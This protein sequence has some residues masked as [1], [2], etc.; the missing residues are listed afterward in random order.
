MA[1]KSAIAT[2]V[3]RI[4]TLALIAASIALLATNKFTVDG[5]KTTFKDVQAYKYVISA[6]LLG[7]L[8]TL[9]QIPFAIYHVAT[10]KRVIRNE[11][12][13]EFDFYADQIV[14]Y[15]LATAVGAGFAV[16][17]EFKKL[18]KEIMGE[19]FLDKGNIATGVLFLG[20]L[21]V[22]A[23]VLISAMSRNSPPPPTRRG[24][25]G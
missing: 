18:V 7:F 8:Y 24:F 14:A 13:P 4:L 23:Q 16:T 20:F 15:I 25:F 2:L 11:C 19:K 5:T 3:L 21:C 9:F 12:L 22:A 17:F 10:E 1:T 6:A